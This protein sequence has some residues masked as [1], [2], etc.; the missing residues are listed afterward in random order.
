MTAEK[1]A[2]CK[3]S[4]DFTSVYYS[5]SWICIS[6]V[7]YWCFFHSA[8]TQFCVYSIGKRVPATIM[9]PMCWPFNFIHVRGDGCKVSFIR[10][11]LSNCRDSAGKTK[12]TTSQT[13]PLRQLYFI[14][15]RAQ[16]TQTSWT[17]GPLS[18]TQYGELRRQE[19]GAARETQQENPHPLVMY[20]VSPPH[21][22]PPVVH[23]R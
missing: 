6:L 13:L 3:C 2:H 21:P 7:R 23:S 19:R 5:V 20:V 8:H 22:L 12:T 16:M 10:Q 9:G 17:H 14:L 15:T 11:S 1:L 4:E 18:K